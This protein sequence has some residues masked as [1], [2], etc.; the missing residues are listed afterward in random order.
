VND[1][2]EISWPGGGPGDVLQETEKLEPPA[3]RAVTNAVLKAGEQTATVPIVSN[4]TLFFRLLA[5]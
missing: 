5:Q 3:W 2:V 1:A 4:R